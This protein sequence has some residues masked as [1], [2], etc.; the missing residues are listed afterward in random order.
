MKDYGYK[1][2]ADV[3]DEKT[4]ELEKRKQEADAELAKTEEELGK[5]ELELETERFILE[6]A[7]KTLAELEKALAACERRVADSKK[8][9]GGMVVG[10]MKAGGSGTIGKGSDVDKDQTSE[11]RC[12]EGE[13]RESK[14]FICSFLILDQ[15]GFIEFKSN[16]KSHPDTTGVG[17]TGAAADVISKLLRLLGL[18]LGLATSA[19]NPLKLPL[20]VINLVLTPVSAGGGAALDVVGRMLPKKLFLTE[21]VVDALRI[22]QQCEERTICLGGRWVTQVNYIGS[23][24]AIREKVTFPFDEV[25]GLRVEDL[26]D[27]LKKEFKRRFADPAQIEKAPCTQCQT[28]IDN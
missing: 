25:A 9:S 28:R 13:I 10:G 7:E 20:G 19:E 15:S 8:N 18:I 23:S 24:P 17:Q 26:F 3:Y 1:T 12:I 27:F 21:V 14:K 22:N 4:K 11:Q 16:F 2:G 6:T 5:I